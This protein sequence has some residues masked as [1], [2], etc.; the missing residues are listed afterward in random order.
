MFSRSRSDERGFTL[1]EL[2]AVMAIIGVLSSISVPIYRHQ[3]QKAA[4]ATVVSD[5]RNMGTY[6]EEYLVSHDGTPPTSIPNGSFQKISPNNVLTLSA[7]GLCVAGTNTKYPGIAWYYDAVRK[8]VTDED[9]CGTVSAPVTVP[10]GGTPG[11]GG[12]AP[13]GGGGVVGTIVNAAV[14]VGTPTAFTNAWNL[15][16][17]GADLYVD[18]DFECN[19]QVT[20]EGDVIVTGNAYLTNVCQ[21]GGDIWVVGNVRMNSSAQV[22]GSVNT[23]GDVS[24]QSTALIG[25]SVNLHGSFST[26][27][28]KTPQWLTSN[29]RIGGTIN[30]GVTV[31]IPIPPTFPKVSFPVAPVVPVVTWSN[32]QKAQAA[33]NPSTPTWSPVFK[34]TGCDITPNASYSLTGP[35]EVKTQTIV[36]ARQATSGCSTVSIGGTA[37]PIVLYADLTL[38][39]NS[40]NAPNGLKVTSGDGQPHIIR[41]LSASSTGV[42]Q[43]SSTNS[44]SMGTGTTFSNDV[45]VLLYTDSEMHVNA[46]TTFNGQ[47][48][49]GCFSANGTVKVTF[50]PV[51]TY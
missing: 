27:D 45:K 18:G 10:S 8:I 38:W 16:G 12:G 6:M 48:I 43:C 44:I 37:A 2:L 40:F 5:L 25:G 33:Q 23:S 41:I 4:E 20:I 17:N 32:W 19:S 47:A 3:Q 11:P 39:V 30:E 14:Y 9:W 42:A 21:V 28:G 7:D 50:A 15:V 49:A 1:I 35:I 31:N 24:F 29:H 26:I 22:T 51:T 34:G 36:D 13:S 46:S